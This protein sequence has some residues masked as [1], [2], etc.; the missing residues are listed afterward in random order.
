VD[1][2]PDNANGMQLDAD[3][4]GKGDACDSCASPNPAYAACPTTIK[5]IRDPNDPNHPTSGTVVSISGAYVTAV[6]PNA[7]SSRGFYV[8]DTSLQPFTGIFVFT[9]SSPP[10]VAVG[11]QVSISG[12]YEEFFML[13]EISSP[14]VT[15]TNAGTTLPFGPIAIANPADIATG[16]AQAEGYESMLL[17]ISAVTVVNANPDAPQDFDEFSVTGNLRI[18]DQIFDFDNTY[19][20]G[21]AFSKIIGIG[22]FS[23]SNYK[24]LPRSA[25]DLVP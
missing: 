19:A 6:R 10:N 1:N 13:S 4:D 7:G 8:Q 18:D 21:T 3:A 16:G 11:N 9:A 20:V 25:A 12:T 14:T 2:C 22:T 5:S 17:E 23:F 24:L 15:V